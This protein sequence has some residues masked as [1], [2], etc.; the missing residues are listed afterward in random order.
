MAEESSPHPLIT[1]SRVKDAPVYNRDGD[2]IGH[3][4]DLSIDKLSGHVVYA[5]MSFGGFLGIGER[6]HPL[7][8]NV[9]DYEIEQDGYVVPLTKAELEAAP[10]YTADELEQFGAGERDLLYQYYGPYGAVPYV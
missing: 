1:A 2:R 7:P 9:L 4:E 3:I 5:L 6:F 10:S 8:W